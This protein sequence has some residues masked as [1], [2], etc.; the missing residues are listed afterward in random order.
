LKRIQIPLILA[1]LTLH[2][3][4]SSAHSVAAQ[5]SPPI[6][7]AVLFYSPS[8]GHCQYVITEVL[9][10][11][12]ARYGA[13]LQIIGFDVTHTNGQAMLY[14]AMDRFGLQEPGV[15][16][17]VIDDLTLVGSQQ[18]PDELPGLI[19]AY[20][21]VGG[22]PW[23]DIPGLEEVLVAAAQTAT[24]EPITTEGSVVPP[25]ATTP[26]ED[27]GSVEMQ[28]S[29]WQQRFASDPIANTIAVVVLLLML[30]ALIWALIRFSR[31]R[32]ASTKEPR[33]PWLIPALCLLGLVVAG[34]L[35]YIES[36]DTAAVCGPIGDCNTV[37]HSPYSHLFGVL[38]MG[39]FGL[40]GYS[41]MLIAWGLARFSKARIAVGATLGLFVLAL[42]GTL[43][44]LV[45]TFLEPFVIG[46]TC[47]WCLTSA[48]VMTLLL[49]SS[50]SPAGRAFRSGTRIPPRALGRRH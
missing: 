43:F 24:A 31:G 25:R 37:Q 26:A 5:E 1:I 44:S 49:L 38:S 15:P 34:Y 29:S 13:Q 12:A 18:I 27:V 22:V 32:G 47:A 9:P 17:L 48:L 6:V 28:P 4:S 36:T 21:K 3:F 19:E 23:P 50:A 7:H 33:G 10:P 35:A 42:L 41:L 14:A 40:I 39:A 20:L 11:L 45:L 16:L 30:A 46:A 8:C 2:S